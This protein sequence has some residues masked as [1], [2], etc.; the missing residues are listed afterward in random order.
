ME[1]DAEQ[2]AENLR[3]AGCGGRRGKKILDL[4]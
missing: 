2:I 3:A 1:I 4:K